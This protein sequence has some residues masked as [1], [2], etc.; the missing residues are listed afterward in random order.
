MGGFERP[1]DLTELGGVG[2]LDRGVLVR[3]FSGH[4]EGRDQ[5][6]TK[7]HNAARAKHREV[8]NALRSKSFS[9]TWFVQESPAS[10]PSRL[11]R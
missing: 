7:R 4:V 3:G 1:R 10:Q 11:K 8:Q 6:F 2:R 9:E 5:L